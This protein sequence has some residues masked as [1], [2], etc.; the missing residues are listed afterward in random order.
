MLRHA[1]PLYKLGYLRS[2]SYDREL[3]IRP[4]CIHTHTQYNKFR[5][6]EVECDKLV[7]VVFT[8]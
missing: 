4:S 7:E 5:S 3:P 2:I 8:V 6:R 1:I